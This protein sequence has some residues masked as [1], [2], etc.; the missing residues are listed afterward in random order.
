MRY[1]KYTGRPYYYRKR[2]N[3]D[4]AVIGVDDDGSKWLLK[5]NGRT[6]KVP[7]GSNVYI[8]FEKNSIKKEITEKEL[9]IEMLW[10]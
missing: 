9:F 2:I 7:L 4:I 10:I 8:R 6:G 3:Y 1:F 5:R